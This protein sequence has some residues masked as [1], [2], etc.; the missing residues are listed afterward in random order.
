[1]KAFT[2]NIYFHLVTRSGYQ[3]RVAVSIAVYN[4]SLRLTNTDR[5]STTLGK[6]HYQPQST[7]GR[8]S[9]F[10]L[11]VTNISHLS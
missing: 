6:Y 5:Q 8:L 7:L 10:S 4:K 11:P 9:P 3:A 2:E 1:M